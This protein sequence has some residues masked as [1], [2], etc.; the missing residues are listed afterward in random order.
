MY[1]LRNNDPNH[2]ELD[3][4]GHSNGDLGAFLIA[5]RLRND[6][7]L[8]KVN[9]SG[10]RLHPGQIRDSGA[11]T[12]GDALKSNHTL[13]QL[14]LRYNQISDFGAWSLSMSLKNNVALTELDLY[15]N[16]ISDGGARGLAELLKQ[17]NIGDAVYERNVDDDKKTIR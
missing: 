14:R 7:I 10:T 2:S 3:F 15:H 12:L 11:C 16:K 8:R 6:T 13:T 1:Q 4:S 17:K 9:L 5:I